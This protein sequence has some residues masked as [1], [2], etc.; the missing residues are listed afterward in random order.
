MAVTREFLRDQMKKLEVNYGMDKFRIT[1]EGFELWYEIFKECDAEGLKIAV[2]KCLEENEFAPNIAGLMKYYR[3]LEQ[4]RNEITEVMKSKYTTMR[5]MWR[6]EY[7]SDTFKAIVE[8]IFRFP[9]EQRKVQM[10]ELTH[11]A[12]SFYND[13]RNVGRQDIPT[14]KEYVEGKR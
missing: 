14:I 2:N 6:E 10:V 11:H 3:T 5:S 4:D 7:D 1:Q 13:C 9:K 12:I 8:Y